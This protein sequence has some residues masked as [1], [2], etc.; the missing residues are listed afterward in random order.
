MKFKINPSEV[1]LRTIEETSGA[2]CE[3]NPSPLNC[4]PNLM[5]RKYKKLLKG[6]CTKDLSIL[7]R[8]Q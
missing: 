2:N 4:N 1:Y 3:E 5:T 6:D 8:F 7:L